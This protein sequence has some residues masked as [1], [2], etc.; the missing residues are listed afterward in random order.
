[1]DK[2]NKRVETNS[3]VIVMKIL[4]VHPYLSDIGGAEE[5]LINILEA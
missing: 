5:V 3:N 2:A 4:V 1:M